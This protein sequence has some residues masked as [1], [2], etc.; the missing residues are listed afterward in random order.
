MNLDLRSPDPDLLSWAQ[1]RVDDIVAAAQQEAK[2]SVDTVLT[3]QW[4]RNPYPRDGVDLAR[5]VAEQIG[6]PYR[7]TQTVA[8]HDSTNMKESVP[9]V[10]LF[11]PSVDG[12]SHNE[13]EFTSDGDMLAGLEMLTA[14]VERMM[15][16]ISRR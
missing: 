10:M 6:I 8:G 9:T 7:E 2:V 16:S 15:V 5:S 1:Q 12:I 11:V 3:H 14:A 13:R 4:D